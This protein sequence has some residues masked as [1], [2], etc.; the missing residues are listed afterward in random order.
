MAQSLISG[1][2]KQL[3]S[4]STELSNTRVEAVLLEDAEKKQQEN[5][6]VRHW[7]DQLKDVSYDI[8]NVVDEWSTE[9][10]ISQIQEQGDGEFNDAVALKILKKVCVSLPSCCFCLNQLEQI[11]IRRETAVKIKQLNDKLEGIAKE[12]RDYSFETTKIVPNKRRETTSFVDVSEVYGRNAD[13]VVL[14]SKLL[15][16]SSSHGGKGPVIIPIVGMGGSGKTTLA[17]LAFND[18]EVKANFDERV[19]V[20]VSDPF[21][22]IGIAKAILQELNVSIQNLHTL[23]ALLQRIVVSIEGKK[24][25]LV[26]DDVWTEDREKW[27]QFIQPF[28]SGAAGSRLLI[29][30]RKKKVATMMGVRTQMIINLELLSE[31]HCWLIFSQLA[32]SE[33]NSEER[34]QLEGIGRKIANKCKGLPLLAKTLGGLMC[35]KKTKTDWEDVLSNQIWKLQDKEIKHFAPFLLSYYDLPPLEQRCFSYCSVF[36]KDYKFERDDLIQMWMSQGFLSSGVNPENEGRNCFENLTMQSFFQDFEKDDDGNVVACKMH[37]ILHDLALFLTKNECFTME[38]DE[39]NIQ[40]CTVEKV[41]HLTLLFTDDSVAFPTSMLNEGNLHSLLMLGLHQLTFIKL[42]LPDR[43][44]PPLRY[45][46]TLNMRDCGISWIPGQLIG[47]LRHLRYLNLS[48]N[49]LKEL[50]D[51]VCD[52]CN[53]QTLRIEHCSELERLPEGMGKLVNLRHLHIFGCDNLKGLPKGIR[54]LTQLQMLDAVVIREKNR[55][56]YLSIGDF[57]KMNYLEL[58]SSSQIMGLGNLKSLSEFDKLA[59]LVKGGN[60]DHLNLFFHGSDF[61]FVVSKEDDEF[62]ILEALQPHPSLKSLSI[63][64]YLGANLSPKW[65]TSLDNLTHLQI[66]NCEFV[67]T[68]PPLGRLPSLEVLGITSNRELRKMGVSVKLGRL[69]VG[70]AK[71]ARGAIDDLLSS[72]DGGKHDY[73]WLLTPPGTPVF[74]SSDGSESQPTLP[75]PRSSSIIRSTSTTKASRL[76]VSQS[77]SNLTSRPTRSSSVTRSSTSTSLYNNYS[78]N[79]SSSILNTSSASVS[80]YTRSSSPITHSPSTAR[81]STPS[82]RPTLSRPSTP[83]RARPAPTSSTIDKTRPGH[84]LSQLFLLIFLLRRHQTLEPLYQ[85]GQFPLVGPDWLLLFPQRG[86]QKP[87]LT[88]IYQ[89]GILHQSLLGEDSLNPQEEGR[90]HGNGH[91]YDVAEVRKA[92]HVPDMA[93]RKPVKSSTAATDSMGFGRSISKKSLDMAIRHMD[94]RSSSGNIRQ[95]SGTTLFPQSIRSAAP[96]MQSVRGLSA[97]ASININGGLQTNN[98]GLVLENGNSIDRPSENG[99]EADSGR[100]CAKLGEVDIYESSR[101]DAVLLKEDLKNTN[102]LHNIDD[103]TDQGPIFFFAIQEWKQVRD[104]EKDVSSIT[105]KLEAI[106]VLLEDAEKK[107]QENPSVRRWLDQLTDVSS[108]IDNVV[109]EWSTEILISQ[110]QEQGDEEVNC[111]GNRIL[112]KVCFSLPSCCVCLNQLEQVAIRRETPVKIKQLNDKLDGIAKERRDYSFETTKILPNKRRE[113]TSFVDV[114]EVYG[115]NADKDV[116]VSKLLCDSSS[117]CDSRSHEVKGPVIIPIVGME[118]IGKAT[119]T[120]LAFNDN[121]VKANFDERVWVCVSVLM[122]LELPKQ[123]FKS[124]MLAFKIYIHCKLHCNVL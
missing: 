54:R 76:L 63:W 4:F 13:K 123:F 9:I 64:G 95:L 48:G 106:Q 120:Q 118:G 113:T 28:R 36:S 35:F 25:L 107:Q 5:P 102:W 81:P 16:D 29:T 8:D 77:E 101:Y 67:N 6:S 41:R 68:F 22:E 33:R 11:A 17:Q 42:R 121:E 74:P 91:H 40:P 32:F 66:Y 3:G 19:W 99:T 12:R 88:V 2:L 85:I 50:P 46:R 49:G 96:K 14:V 92:Q 78:S 24:F 100:D 93:M 105:S 98:N 37:D 86:I 15:C 122:R 45:L 20:C 7:L 57:E 65:M 79:R 119:L 108:D 34:Q 69:S 116:L 72:T 73:D 62:M 53:L 112:K 1:V 38:V 114:S 117:D 27:E 47:Q 70:S 10:L 94:I 23:Q 44:S 109:D 26:L 55:E 80:S 61:Q 18:N 103:K 71:V 89:K 82:S 52:L 75:A 90:V 21:N 83:S 59:G 58:E 97:A 31:E 124:S 115:R 30:T 110:I 43:T 56:E 51:E 39:G 111:W 84:L 60:R 87:H 104:V